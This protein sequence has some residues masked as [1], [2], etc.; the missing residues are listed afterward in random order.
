M[1]DGNPY[2]YPDNLPRVNANGGPEG[3]P[4]QL[5]RPQQPWQLIPPLLDHPF[6]VSISIDESVN[7]DYMTSLRQHLNIG[8]Y[9]GLG[10]IFT[11]CPRKGK[12][13]LANV[14]DE[15]VQQIHGRGRHIRVAFSTR[16]WITDGRSPT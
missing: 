11:A 10:G 6:A 14:I 16:H 7:N 12:Q 13:C 8:M 2:V 4:G 3:R 15:S 5:R 1:G 9:P